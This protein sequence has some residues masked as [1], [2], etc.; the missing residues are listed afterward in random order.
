MRFLQNVAYEHPATRA[1]LPV[2]QGL[3]VRLPKLLGDPAW[4]V[5]LV[6]EELRIEDFQAALALW[7]WQR[8][9]DAR[10]VGHHPTEP[11]CRTC[12][13]E[14]DAAR[15]P[16]TAGPTTLDAATRG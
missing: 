13:A 6:P 16:A 8:L 2:E 5:M 12:D 3:I 11:P 7:R 10:P 15:A 4:E 9:M 1:G 14:L